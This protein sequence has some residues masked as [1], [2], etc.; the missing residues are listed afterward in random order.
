VL[1]RD[2]VEALGGEKTPGQIAKKYGVHP[3]SL[4]LWK[5]AFLERGPEVFAEDGTVQQYECRIAELEQLVGKKEVEIA[6]PKKLL[7]P[8]RMST[9]QKVVLAHRA[10]GKTLGAAL[11]VV[12]LP[13]STW[14]YRQKHARAY[15]QKYDNL[16]EPLERVARQHPDLRRLSP[17]DGGA[18]G[19]LRAPNQPQGGAEASPGVGSAADADYQATETQRDPAGDHGGR[20]SGVSGGGPRRD[21]AF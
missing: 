5:K 16:R 21:Q 18:Q 19:G 3:N 7:G 15:T 2:D 1:G 9:G 6:L 11:A 10:K 14:Y 17:D 8:E 12:E 20:G 13:R 4:A